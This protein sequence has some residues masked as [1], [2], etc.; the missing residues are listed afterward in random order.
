[1]ATAGRLRLA[2]D[3]FDQFQAGLKRHQFSMR[4]R[5]GIERRTGLLQ[6]CKESSSIAVHFCHPRQSW[7]FRVTSQPLPTPVDAAILSP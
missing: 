1:M 2:N 4:Y 5:V 7:Q 3:R 6:F